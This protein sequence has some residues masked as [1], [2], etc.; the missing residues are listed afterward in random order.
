[1]SDAAEVEAA[2]VDGVLAEGWMTTDNETRQSLETEYRKF[3]ADP[4]LIH[5]LVMHQRILETWERSSPKMYARLKK[6]GTLEMTAF[7]SQQRMWA[8]RDL[9]ERAGMPPTDARE[10]AE[11][12]WLMLEPEDDPDEEKVEDEED[13]AW[14][15]ADLEK[16]RA[17]AEAAKALAVLQAKLSGSQFK[18]GF[19]PEIL[20][21]GIT[22]AG[23]HIEKGARSFTAY[24]RAMIDDMGDSVRPFLKSWYLGVRFDPRAAGFDGM[25]GA[26]EVDAADVDGIL[27]EKVG[28]DEPDDVIEQEYRNW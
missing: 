7:V 5:N 20:Q 12:G 9:L 25:S 24:T 17:E 16:M 3:K 22:L 4:E 19:D 23:Y 14:P 26:A 11:K 13:Y 27:T 1:M 18:T 10:E 15:A 21:A 2:D 28:D 8:E 6:A